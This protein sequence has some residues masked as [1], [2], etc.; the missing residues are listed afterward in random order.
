MT[1]IVT[2]LYYGQQLLVAYQVISLGLQ[3]GTQPKG[4]WVP[5]AVPNPS[6][7]FSVGCQ[8]GG[9][10]QNDAGYSKS[11]SVRLQADRPLIVEISEYQSL[12][13]LAPEASKSL[14]HFLRRL[15]RAKDLA[16]LASF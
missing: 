12:G 14:L 7:L 6:S 11:R 8:R 15:K 9:G 10:L 1:Q 5:V 2:R 3:L 16:L 4:D 13:E